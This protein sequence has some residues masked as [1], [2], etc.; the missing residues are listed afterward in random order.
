MKVK[1]RNSSL[2]HRRKT[3][4]LT[5]KKTRG[6]RRVIANQRRAAAGGQKASRIVK[7]RHQKSKARAKA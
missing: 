3:G 1:I 7:A 4:F 6:G 5:R 2:K